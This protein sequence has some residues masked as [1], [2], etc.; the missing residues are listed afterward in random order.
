[1]G[2]HMKNSAIVPAGE[3][4]A[5]HP[6]SVAAGPHTLHGLSSGHVLLKG[7]DPEEFQEH[8]AAF[9]D[10][11][12]P[13]GKIEEEL[14]RRIAVLT[15]RLRRIERIEAETW[16]ELAR[17][18]QLEVKVREQSDVYHA[19]AMLMEPPP[20]LEAP[21]PLQPQPASGEQEAATERLREERLSRIREVLEAK[22][23]AWS[24]AMA[25]PSSRYGLAAI[26]DKAERAFMALHRY[27]FGLQRG[28]MM[29]TM[30]LESL[31]S[32]RGV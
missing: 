32:R 31:Q 23:A 13:Q 2:R 9:F 3:R 5:A 18:Q 21:A 22:V 27:E 28:L 10:Q 1:M 8:A 20:A 4:A 6:A 17:R 19:V 29:A 16:D 11:Y 25:T 14:A 24:E 26:C 30:Q 12:R 15:W 7:E